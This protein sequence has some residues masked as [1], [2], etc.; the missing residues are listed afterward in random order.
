MYAGWRP[1][2]GKTNLDWQASLNDIEWFIRHCAEHFVAGGEYNAYKHGLRVVAGS[3][4]IGVAARGDTEVKSIVAL[5]LISGIVT[6]RS[7]SLYF[8][9]WN[10]LKI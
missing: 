10:P 1:G 9:Q 4:T 2:D 8:N 6:L 7:D 5:Y 3:L